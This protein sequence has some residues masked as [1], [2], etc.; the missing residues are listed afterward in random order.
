[1]EELNINL[2]ELEEI[3][4]AFRSSK[5]D[6]PTISIGTRAIYFNNYCSPLME[7]KDAVKWFASTDYIIG[8]PAKQL[9][10]NAFAIREERY[11]N[12]R[13]YLAHFPAR[14][15]KEKKI[16][17]GCYKLYKYKDG[18]AFKRYEPLTKN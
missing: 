11:K 17:P 5:Y 6:F 15:K 14:L 9:E 3:A 8:I 13:V 16:Q 2:G 1:M 10:N 4:K 7:G 12:V 18:F